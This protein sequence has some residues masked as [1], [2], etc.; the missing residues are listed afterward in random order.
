MQA[1]NVLTDRV[2][3]ITKINTEVADWLQVIDYPIISR[4]RRTE[5]E[6]ASPG[7]PSSRGTVCPEFTEAHEFQ[8]SQRPVRARVGRFSLRGPST[9]LRANRLSSVFSG[10]WD[11]IVLSVDATAHSHHQ[12]ASLLEKDVEAPLRNFQARKE[13]QNMQTISANLTAMARDLEDAQKK[14]DALARKGPKTNAQKMADATARLEQATQQWDS[15]APFIFETLQALDEQRVNQ[16]RDLLT[17]YQTHESD[18]A[19]RSQSKAA[20]TLALMLEISTEQE[21]ASFKEKIVSGRPRMEKRVTTSRQSSNV[22]T[23]QTLAPPPPPSSSLGH[24]DDDTSDHSG[25]MEG[26]S[27]MLSTT[28]MTKPTEMADMYRRIEAAESNRHD[29]RPA[30]TEHPR[31][32]RSDFSTEDRRFLVRPWP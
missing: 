27:G 31:W 7:A 29:A 20:E 30:P 23:S 21:I 6:P 18:Q 15:Q 14:M 9:V 4:E 17:Q 13:M 32:L 5:A 3:R 2:K 25:A 11:K 16:L 8:S 19:Q 10:P 28:I 26:K 24:H 1:V 12:F 22:P